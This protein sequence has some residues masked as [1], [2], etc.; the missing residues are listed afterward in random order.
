M[1]TSLWRSLLSSVREWLDRLFR[2]PA[3]KEALYPRC[4]EELVG[5]IGQARDNVTSIKVVG[6]TFPTSYL[7]GDIVVD[8]RL[9]DRLLGLDLQQLTVTTEPGMRLSTLSSFLSSVNL[10]LDMAGRV[11]DLA[12]MDL[13]ALGSA[14]MGSSPLNLSTCLLSVTVV[15]AGKEE[16]V[17]WS[18]DT[19]PR[20]MSALV[21]GLGMVAVV[22]SATFRVT[23]LVS[24]TEISYL[25]SVREVLD[26]WS[27]VHRTSESQQLQWFPFTKLVVISHTSPLAKQSGTEEQ[28]RLHQVL[29]QISLW[30]ARVIR[31]IN[32]LLFTNLPLLSS[33]LARVQF[34]SQWTAARH[35]SDYSHHPVQFSPCSSLRGSTWLVALSDLP[36]LL[37]QISSWS[38]THPGPVSSPIY[39]QTMVQM[40]RDKEAYLAPQV[41]K[42]PLTT[43]WYDWFLPETTPDPLVVS[44]FESLFHEIGGVRC[45]SAERLV[46]PLLLSN[47]C[48]GYR[49]WC[50]VKKELDPACLLSSGY[51]RGTVFSMPTRKGTEDQREMTDFNSSMLRRKITE[52]Q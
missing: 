38:S 5:V 1:K 30:V 4:D 48:P 49:E 45:W 17:T 20:F 51:V 26:T 52:E 50:R 3:E 12:V 6:G 47:T 37:H 25:T 36:S 34:I 46:S 10:T 24:V 42:V 21:S 9:M 29:E 39:I 27:L 16:P 41:R 7:Q 35:R 32:I 8:T 2:R 40:D 33:I 13:L 11:P 23:S 18:W 31:R 15:T 19:H 28:P 43:V 44:H 22:L 14:G